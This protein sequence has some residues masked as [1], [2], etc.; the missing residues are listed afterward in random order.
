VAGTIGAVAGLGCAV[1]VVDGWLW[2]VPVLTLSVA[3]ARW[4]VVPLVPERR[5]RRNPVDDD[6]VAGDSAC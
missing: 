5:A 2:P 1:V 4:A 6:F 3:A